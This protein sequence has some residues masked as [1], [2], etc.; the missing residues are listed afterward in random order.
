MSG[1]VGRPMPTRSRGMACKGARGA[2]GA[3]VRTGGDPALAHPTPCRIEGLTHIGVEAAN[4]GT[5]SIVAPARDERRSVRASLAPSPLTLCPV[6]TGVG[7]PAPFQLGHKFPYP[8]LT[9]SGPHLALPPNFRAS[10]PSGL[11]SSS[12]TR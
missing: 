3:L 2:Q 6:D 8:S 12:C 1:C 7:N 9:S 11:S 4:T 5:D 10:F